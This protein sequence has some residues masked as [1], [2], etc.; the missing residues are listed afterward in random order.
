MK[1]NLLRLSGNI[2]FEP[3]DKTRKHLN[4][5]SWKKIAMV[6]VDGD[7]CEYYS[8]FI[9]RRYNLILNKPLRGAHIS[10]INDSMKDLTQNGKKSEEEV[11]NAWE[12]IKQKWHGKTIPIVID[13]EVRTNGRTWWFNVPHEERE[14][15]QSIRS[16]L[17]LGKPFFG[18]HMSIGYA[19]PGIMEEH[20]IYINDLIKN[21]F[22]LT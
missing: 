17:G 19:R 3:E 2:Q 6:M 21:K 7:I 16:E 10:F 8:W 5:A 18:L 22:I 15:L 20:S 9:K 14:L 4:Q 11:L 13:L 1:T 12:T